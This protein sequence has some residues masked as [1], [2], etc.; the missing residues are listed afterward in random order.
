MSDPMDPLLGV[1]RPPD[2]VFVSGEGTLLIDEDGRSYLDF[3]SGIGV[4]ALGHG[5]PIVR[6][7][8]EDALASGLVHASNLF[9]TRPA[10]RLA[11]LLTRKA[12]LDRVFFCNSGGESVEGALK[13]AKKWAKSRGG[14]DKHRIVALNGSFHGRLF[15]SLAV[16]DR[17]DYRAP[18][19]PLMPGVDFASPLDLSEV[20]RTLSGE[21]T[22]ALIVEP[23][24]GEGGIQPLS[25]EFLQAVRGWTLD[26]DIALILDEVQCGLGRTGTLFA[27]EPSGILPDLLC[28]AKPLG[29]GLP[30]GAVILSREIADVMVPGDHG[31]T[32]GGGP[33]VSSVALAVLE[34]AG[35]PSFLGEVRAR[36]EYLSGLLTELSEQYPELVL[37][38][39]GRGLLW[40]MELS[41]PAG[42]IVERAREHGLLTVPAGDHVLRLLPPLTVTHPE[43]D[44][45]AGILERV[46][47]EAS[48]QP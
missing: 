5:S 30:M 33:L 15:G 46:F 31:T 45:A 34:V 4:N 48:T 1:Y 38:V 2:V 19:D 11:R 47:E 43:I 8:I 6:R 24:Q 40:G 25:S 35:D 28:I 21:H 32:F 9:R 41:S 18:F 22:A 3:T 7:A 26:R 12:G 13:F 42:P 36:G 20:D 27:F 14:A 17:P 16:T 39:R 29:G 10:A 23:I 44:R 37:E